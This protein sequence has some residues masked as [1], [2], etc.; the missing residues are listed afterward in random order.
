VKRKA[1]VKQADCDSM[2]TNAQAL[3]QSYERRASVKR[4]YYEKQLQM[5]KVLP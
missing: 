4:R 2:V 5:M 3:A 1:D